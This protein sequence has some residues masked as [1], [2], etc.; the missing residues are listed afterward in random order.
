MLAP[1]RPFMTK[2]YT[3]ESEKKEVNIRAA[4]IEYC[5]QNLRLDK[6]W[7]EHISKHGGVY[8]FM[9]FSLLD[10]MA[11][12]SATVIKDTHK[13][14]TNTAEILEE[15]NNALTLLAGIR[16]SSSIATMAYHALGKVAESFPQP[17][18]TTQQKKKQRIADSK[19]TTAFS[20]EDGLLRD[21]IDPAMLRDSSESSP[22]SQPQM[23]TSVTTPGSCQ[24][25]EAVSSTPGNNPGHG[26]NLAVNPYLDE[27]ITQ[28]A[29]QDVGSAPP[30]GQ[31]SGAP[32]LD[33]TLKSR[34][35]FTALWDWASMDWGIHE[36]PQQK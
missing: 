1:M 25:V 2:Q 33:D 34:Y 29:E 17:D 3:H 4:G 21:T 7:V 26:Q 9:L 28:A 36:R 22:E 35:E 6:A 24:N 8:H 12:L 5:L 30:A 20:S 16:G 32:G 11:L 23:M 19:E 27:T 10:T 15:V 14:I 31:R 13:M 18:V